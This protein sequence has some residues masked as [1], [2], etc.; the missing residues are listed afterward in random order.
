MAYTDLF[1]STSCRLSLWQVEISYIRA[2]IDFFEQCR[3]LSHFIAFFAL[4]L[5]LSNYLTGTPFRL[6]DRMSRPPV[7]L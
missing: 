3:Y 6:S 5:A 7:T 1:L 4:K 2:N